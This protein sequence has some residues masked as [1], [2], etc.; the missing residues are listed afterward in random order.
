MDKI[1]VLHIADKLSLGGSTIH[2]V[3]QLFSWWFPIFNHDRYDVRLCSLR[4][5]DKAGEYLEGVGIQVYYLGRKKYDPRILLDLL[6]LVKKQDFQILHLHGYASCT[7]G[8][9]LARLAGLPAVVHEHMYDANIPSYQRWADRVLSGSTA[10]SIAVSHSVKDFLVRDR[11]VPNQKVEIIYNGAPLSFFR[12]SPT[13]LSLEASLTIGWKE[14]LGIPAEDRV[15]A[16]V[17]RLHP[18]KGHTYFLQAAQRVLKDYPR[19]TFVVVGD[20]ELMEPLIQESQQLAIAHKVIFMGYCQ[21]VPGLLREVDIKVIASL[22]EGIPLTLFEAM[23][24]ACPVVSTQVGGIGEI[25]QDGYT[26]YLVPPRD[27]AALAGP[28][29]RLLCDPAL[30]QAM[31]S[32]ACQTA[33][34]FDVSNNVRQFEALYERLIGQG[35]SRAY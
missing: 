27:P 16:I 6:S 15:V 21:D 4:S 2:G 8:R 20:G 34:K 1:N 33:Q 26:G 22:S 12:G 18:V 19:V 25:L 29:I 31:S 23:A 35:E 3:S 7:F 30:R 24:A 11:S 14:K 10:W 9:V 32:A 5:R 17:G 13:P 28:I